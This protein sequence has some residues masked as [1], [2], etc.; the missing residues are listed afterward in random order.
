MQWF[1][2]KVKVRTSRPA[3]RV[4]TKT[5]DLAPVVGASGIPRGFGLLEEPELQC[6]D[7]SKRD[8]PS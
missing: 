5:N 3:T 4:P 1:R 7:A 2:F 6:L 8:S